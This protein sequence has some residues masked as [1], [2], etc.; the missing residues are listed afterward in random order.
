M[1]SE[2]RETVELGDAQVGCPRCDRSHQQVTAPGNTPWATEGGKDDFGEWDFSPAHIT[3]MHSSCCHAAVTKA[4][5]S[6]LLP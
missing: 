5:D 4:G 6:S 3:F 1:D 2:K